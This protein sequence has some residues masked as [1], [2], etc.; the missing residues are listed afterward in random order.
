MSIVEQYA[1]VHLLDTQNA[2]GAGG[3]AVFDTRMTLTQR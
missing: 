3:V 1:P 2:N